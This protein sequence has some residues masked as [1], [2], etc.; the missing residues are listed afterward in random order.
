VAAPPASAP[1]RRRFALSL[2]LVALVMAVGGIFTAITWQRRT[3]DT[4]AEPTATPAATPPATP[5]ASSIPVVPFNRTVTTTPPART[6][7]T[8]SAK[9]TAGLTVAQAVSRM[10]S[11]VLDGAAAGEIRADVATD[12][13]NLV[14]T[15]SKSKAADA[16]GQVDYLRVKLRQRQGEGESSITQARVTILQARLDDLDRAVGA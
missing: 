13:L 1:P 9:P 6:S 11:A 2:A 14:E 5:T 3:A 15:L 12:L 4:A 10:R 8:P 16:A 7:A